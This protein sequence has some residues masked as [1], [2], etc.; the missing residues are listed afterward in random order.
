MPQFDIHR[1]PARN[2]VNA[3]F[4][5]V[6]QT[7]AL[8]SIPTRLVAPLAV[9]PFGPQRPGERI[10]AI[11]DRFYTIRAEQMFAVPYRLLGPVLGSVADQTYAV[12]SA[13]DA[14]IT[15]AYS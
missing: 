9:R 12:L 1:N 7:S 6:V 3:P 2:R 10:V 4:V 5:I 8:D 15:T 11:D 14:I 13:I